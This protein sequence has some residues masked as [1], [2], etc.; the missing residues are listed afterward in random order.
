MQRLQC[1]DV[2]GMFLHGGDAVCRGLRGGERSDG[3][4]AREDCGAANGL[5]VEDRVLAAR[6][7][8]DELNAA[9][10]DEVDGIG[11]ALVDF[12]DALDDEARGFKHV[13]GAFGGD[14][15]E[16]EIDVAAR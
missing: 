15:F 1:V 10:L 11:P 7:V 9:F 6:G 8:D 5:L 16:A 4:N 12:E 14:D 3:G 2:D 13:G